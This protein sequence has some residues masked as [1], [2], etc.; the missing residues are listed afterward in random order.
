MVMIAGYANA[1]EWNFYGSARV[2]TF[3]TSIETI[4]T[5]TTADVAATKV[6]IAIIFFMLIS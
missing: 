2:S 1:A 6:A 4:A 3:W 5:P